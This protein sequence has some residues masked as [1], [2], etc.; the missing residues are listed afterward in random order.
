MKKINYR[1]DEEKLPSYSI[2]KAATEGNVD[3]INLILKHYERYILKLS[4][5]MIYDK[6]GRLCYDVDEALRR[7]LETKLITKT[8]TFK[9]DS[10]WKKMQYSVESKTNDRE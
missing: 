9:L 5:R 3:A 6:T 4:T 2:I 10:D 1:L 7:R 8:L